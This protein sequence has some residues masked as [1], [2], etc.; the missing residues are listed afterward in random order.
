MG[1]L[2][3]ALSSG[4]FCP[5]SPGGSTCRVGA[6]SLVVPLITPH[7]VP[8]LQLQPRAPLPGRLHQEPRGNTCVVGSS[9]PCGFCRSRD[10][11]RERDV[12]EGSWHRQT[13]CC[14][15][16]HHPLTAF[17]I[18]IGAL[19]IPWLPLQ[20]HLHQIHAPLSLHFS[21][22]LVS[23]KNPSTFNLHK[24]HLHQATCPSTYV[25]AFFLWSEQVK[26]PKWIHF[27]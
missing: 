1:S 23:A 24:V 26:L 21:V 12:G 25:P 3:C 11:E 6:A 19:L 16:W 14:L 5:R 18:T 7:A 22:R 13:L 27:D 2:G 15:C 10:T 9:K 4:L 8:P 17:G 20:R